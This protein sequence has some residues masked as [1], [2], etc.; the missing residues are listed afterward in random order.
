MFE[1]EPQQQVR[2]VVGED[3][4]PLF[5]AKDVAEALG[6]VWNGSAAIAHVPEKWRVVRSVLTTSG[7]KE[8]PTLTEQGLYFFLGR[9]DKPKALPFQMWV[10]EQV[11]PSIMATGS[12]SLPSAQ[13][14]SVARPGLSRPQEQVV[15]HFAIAEHLAKLPGVK[16]GLITSVALAAI[17]TDTGLTM[18]PYRQLLPAGEIGP[19]LINPTEL[20]EPLGMLPQKVNKRLA[21]LGFQVRSEHGDRKAWV[22]TE[23][24]AKWGEMVPFTRRGHS[25]LQPLWKPAVRG[26]L[27]PTDTIAA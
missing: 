8:M 19:A 27:R 20:G 12:Y 26:L 11:V 23:A 13:P 10:A 5:V 6:Y 15:A 25:G 3:G 22:L 14:V 18:E 16:T 9:S 1:F 4:R 21:E 7:T 24:G 2:T 17:H